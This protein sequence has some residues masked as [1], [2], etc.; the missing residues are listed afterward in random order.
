MGMKAKGTIWKIPYLCP[1]SNGLLCCQ[2]VCGEPLCF[3]TESLLVRIFQCY[4][5]AVW[6]TGQHTGDFGEGG[7]SHA[8]GRIGAELPP[9]QP[10]QGLHFP[11]V[12]S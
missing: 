7:Y 4:V 5:C 10:C 3:N 2:S 11:P 9:P 8:S 1:H 12:P 6:Y